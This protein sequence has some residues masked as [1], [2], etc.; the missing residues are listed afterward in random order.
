MSKKLSEIEKIMQG[1]TKEDLENNP[2]E[3]LE[4]P[5]EDEDFEE[6]EGCEEC[7][8]LNIETRPSGLIVCNGCHHIDRRGLN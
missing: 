6:G 3:P 2:E 1:E 7:G 5:E 8:S 4:E